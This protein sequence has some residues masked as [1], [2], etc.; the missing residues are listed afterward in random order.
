MP[1]IHRV[2]CQNTICV[3]GL[4]SKAIPGSFLLLW[5]DPWL[6]STFEKYCFLSRFY[7]QIKK[8]TL[9]TEVW[10]TPHP[11]VCSLRSQGSN[12][13]WIS[14]KFEACHIK[15]CRMF[16][17]FMLNKIWNSVLISGLNYDT[18]LNY[19]ITCVPGYCLILV[20]IRVD[21][22]VILEGSPERVNASSWTHHLCWQGSYK[23]FFPYPSPLQLALL[24]YFC[25]ICVL[26]KNKQ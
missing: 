26:L 25:S 8:V 17:C 22:N 9:D 15:I 4:V 19:F 14:S 13:C 16:G 21:I 7:K 10:N 23:A 2:W 3:R 5:W 11:S 12:I 20:F 18:N 24:F 6:S 1:E